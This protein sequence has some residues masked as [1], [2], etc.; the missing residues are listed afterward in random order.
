MNISLIDLT[1]QKK[2][3]VTI[4]LFASIDSTTEKTFVDG[5]GLRL[6]FARNSVVRRRQISLMKP[7]LPGVKKYT[8]EFQVIGKVYQLLPA[9][10]TFEKSPELVLPRIQTR[11]TGEPTIGWWEQTRLQW[12]PLQSVVTDSTVKAFIE[13]FAQFAV[14]VGNEPLG[15]HGLSFLPTPF[16]PRRGVMRIGY[17]LT[18]DEGR[19]LITIRIYNM[20]GDLV[21]TL[22]DRQQQYPGAHTGLELAWDGRTDEGTLARNGRY[23]VEVIAET[24]S[25]KVRQVGTVVLV[26]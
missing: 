13:S 6:N 3:T 10:A 24:V 11:A 2:E 18:S 20:N 9:G 14:L 16:S 23:L 19:A 12:Q 4:N 15:I 26:K 5:T 17:V 25:G 22:V 1:S 7:N 21:R 8:R